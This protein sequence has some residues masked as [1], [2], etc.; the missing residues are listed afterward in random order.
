MN[1]RVLV[2]VALLA[3]AALAGCEGQPPQTE[4]VCDGC[5]TGLNETAPDVTVEDSVTYVSLREAGDARVEA[6]IRLSGGGVDELRVNETRREAVAE[7]I[8]SGGEQS[9][10]NPYEDRTRPAFPREDL[11]VE[12]DGETL[13]VTYRWANVTERRVGGTAFSDRFYRMD[14]SREGENDYDEPVE[15]ETDRLVV[16]GPDG[17]ETLLTP[18]DTTDRGDRLVW[19]DGRVDPRTYLAFGSGSRFQGRV[20]AALDVVGWVAPPALLS[21]FV[22]AVG[23][24][25]QGVG[26]V[27]YYR[28]RLDRAA[29]WDPGSDP[30]F[31][32]LVGA[33]LALAAFALGWFFGNVLVGIVATLVTVAAVVIAFARVRSDDSDDPA[34]RDPY[35]ADRG[36]DAS[37]SGGETTDSAVDPSRTDTAQSGD[38]GSGQSDGTETR[39]SIG[40]PSPGASISADADSDASGL[41]RFHG[42]A[43]ALV[44]TVLLAGA[45]TAALAADYTATYAG[46][47]ALVAAGVPLATFPVLGYLVTDAGR[48]PSVVGAV[49]VTAAAPWVVSFAQVL[50]SGAQ[51]ATILAFVLVGWAVGVGAVGLLAFYG[52]LWVSTR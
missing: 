22:P 21:A 7:R 41:A 24:L 38:G 19:T 13:V 11:A 27:G 4:V 49:G 8:R 33:E 34:S 3:L 23:L 12:M 16:H 39:Q 32:V 42:H 40:V 1:R 14:A 47:V 26:L 36:P 44:L 31:W 29:G 18:P 15:F 52:V 51:D 10:S 46:T 45:V 50:H 37:P 17:T 6:R 28:R 35:A 2:A 25:G 48:G 43:V 5:V 20:A 30:L 9:D